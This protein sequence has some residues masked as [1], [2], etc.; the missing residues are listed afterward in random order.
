MKF[1]RA[2]VPTPVH[3]CHNS[4]NGSDP[5]RT[6]LCL[7]GFCGRLPGHGGAIEDE[8]ADCSAGM[9][10]SDRDLLISWVFKGFQACHS[11]PWTA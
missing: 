2:P 7:K 4:P 8:S 11:D 6:S 1:K 10:S 5:S 3:R 9:K